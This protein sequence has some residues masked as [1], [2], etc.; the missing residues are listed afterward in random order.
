MAQVLFA[1]ATA[2]LETDLDGNFN[3]LYPIVTKFALATGGLSYATF[4][5]FGTASSGVANVNN[6]WFGVAGTSVINHISGSAGGMV[7]SYFGYNG[8]AIGSISQS[9]TTG[10]AYNTSSDY[11][12]KGSVAPI[13]GSGAFIDALKPC[14]WTWL[15]DGTTGAGFIAHELQAVSPNS[16]TGAKDAVDADGKPVY[17]AVEYG[18]AE[19]IAMLVAELKAVRV[20]L[21]A[22][23]GH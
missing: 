4:M 9:G 17:Q 22:L 7:Y 15:S 20:R 1:A 3:D 14:T 6:C 12:L 21:H 2:P 5:S 19:V 18:S 23:D 8:S 13:A 16:V 11:R 10:V